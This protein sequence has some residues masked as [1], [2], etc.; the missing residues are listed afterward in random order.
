M[1]QNL[2]NKQLTKDAPAAGLLPQGSFEDDVQTALRTFRGALVE[3]LAAIAPE[4]TRPADISRQLG[5]DRN[6]AWRLG[7]ILNSDDVRQTMA[8]VPGEGGVNIFVRGLKKAGGSENSRER[9]LATYQSYRKAVKQ[10]L[11]D[12]ATAELALDNMAA[13]AAGE[14]LELSRKL[15]FRG[16]S[17]IWGIQARMRVQTGFV[18]PCAGQPDMAAAALVAGWVDF[19]RLRRDVRWSL[20]KVRGWNDDGT[21]LPHQDRPIDPAVDPNGPRLIRE[22][23][24]PSMPE[25]LS[26]REGESVCHELGD[27]PVGN[28]GAFTCFR[29]SLLDCVG[30]RYREPS[31]EHGQFF[32]LVSA[33]VETLLFDLFV[34]VDLMPTI[35]PEMA[36]YGFLTTEPQNINDRD[37]LPL[38]ER[39]QELGSR[40][41]VVATPLLPRYGELYDYV[42][43]N[44]GWNPA[45]FR[46]V[47]LVLKYPPFPSTVVLRFPLPERPA[48]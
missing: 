40:P 7:R 15:A 20:F 43:R 46:G 27:T 5:I 10:H 3:A 38:T 17:G 34:H 8:H 31:N 45:E 47:R 28:R 23:C 44:A 13:G 48:S 30:S 39:F 9:V 21:P 33:P 18:A 11:G 16:N 4:L 37:R 19:R 12:R 42:C 25:V 24:S 1:P 6:L 29:G 35:E 41:P 36:V 26:L 14:R 22:F 2:D 32:A